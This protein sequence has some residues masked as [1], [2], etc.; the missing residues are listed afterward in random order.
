MKEEVQNEGAVSCEGWAKWRTLSVVR[1]KMEGAACEGTEAQSEVPAAGCRSRLGSR[2]GALSG[3]CNMELE[4]VNSC[5]C[6]VCAGSVST[7]TELIT[8][9]G[10]TLPP[11]R[12]LSDPNP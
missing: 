4:C 9:L 6:S 11:A 3:R 12:E 1:H 10:G 2:A 7:G 5:G 8:A